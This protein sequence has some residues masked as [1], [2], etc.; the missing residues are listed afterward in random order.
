M[1]LYIKLYSDVNTSIWLDQIVDREATWL[2]NVVV[3]CGRS[4]YILVITLYNNNIAHSWLEEI[5][6]SKI[7]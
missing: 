4:E 6:D 5:V 7:T 3:V 1:L 2:Q